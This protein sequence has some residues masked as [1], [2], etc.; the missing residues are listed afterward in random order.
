MAE[1]YSTNFSR[2]IKL[3]C[4]QLVASAGLIPGLECH[5]RQLLIEKQWRFLHKKIKVSK[6]HHIYAFWSGAGLF[7]HTRIS[8][9]YIFA[10]IKF[11]R[12]NNLFYLDTAHSAA[13]K[14]LAGNSVLYI[15]G[16]LFRRPV[17][18]ATKVYNMLHS[19]PKSSQNCFN[20]D[21]MLLIAAPGPRRY[22]QSRFGMVS[23]RA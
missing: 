16:I 11:P 12:R 21:K 23:G 10:I 1:Q 7:S 5:N 8:F 20:N 3:T 4:Y 2:W 14:A 17:M 15:Y 22:A 19:Y 9:A 18:M 6:G 13:E